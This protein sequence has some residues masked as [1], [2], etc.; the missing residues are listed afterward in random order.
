MRHTQLLSPKFTANLANS[1]LASWMC[2]WCAS[3][4]QVKRRHENNATREWA[5]SSP[6]RY[7]Q[8]VAWAD[9]KETVV[10]SCRPRA[11]RRREIIPRV[12]KMN[13][14]LNSLCGVEGFPSL[15]APAQRRKRCRTDP[16]TGAPRC[17]PPPRRAGLASAFTN[18]RRSRR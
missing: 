12:D 13:R 3:V 10:V 11:G 7:H 17:A 16:Q 9:S 1:L 2:A 14:D 5:T 6:P 18:F 4:L 8:V 15:F